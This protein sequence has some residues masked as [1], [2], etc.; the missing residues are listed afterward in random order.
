MGGSTS[1]CVTAAKGTPRKRALTLASSGITRKM[2]MPVLAAI[3]ASLLG[4]AGAP[5]VAQATARLCAVRDLEV[6]VL[7]K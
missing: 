4:M 1:R 2:L 6:V 5:P 7:I 3:A